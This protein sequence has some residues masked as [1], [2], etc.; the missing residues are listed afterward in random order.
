MSGQSS[1]ETT[2]KTNMQNEH[3]RKLGRVAHVTD[4]TFEPREREWRTKMGLIVDK[5]KPNVR[6]PN[7]LTTD[8]IVC[9]LVTGVIMVITLIFIFA[10]AKA[11]TH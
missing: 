3:E 10:Y 6:K 1:K 11:S 2:K 9:L 5:P 8:F 4:N 7:S